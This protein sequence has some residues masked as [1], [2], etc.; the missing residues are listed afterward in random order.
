MQFQTE[1]FVKINNTYTAKETSKQNV[2]A[3]LCKHF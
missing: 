1:K 2:L 3:Q